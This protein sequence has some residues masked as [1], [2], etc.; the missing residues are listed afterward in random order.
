MSGGNHDHG[1]MSG[2]I[3][4]PAGGGHEIEKE[5]G[6]KSVI[7]KI[8]EEE[9]QVKKDDLKFP[10][11][12]IS[13]SRPKGYGEQSVWQ[14]V[15]RPWKPRDD[16]LTPSQLAAKKRAEKK[17]A[18]AEAERI[19]QQQSTGSASGASGDVEEAEEDDEP[20]DD[21]GQDD[22]FHFYWRLSLP[23]VYTRAGAVGRRWRA[24]EY[25]SP[26]PNTIQ[27]EPRVFNVGWILESRLDEYRKTAAA[28]DIVIWQPKDD[29]MK[30]IKT[31]LGMPTS[32]ISNTKAKT[33]RPC[34]PRRSEKHFS[35]TSWALKKERIFS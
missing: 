6:T 25:P 7:D 1:N 33:T 4:K 15:K 22:K 32:A 29:E 17:R 30:R 34:P 3:E 16:Q 9:E 5:E 26:E 23:Q 10:A 28:K 8:P 11:N 18:T 19:K 31:A 21:D 35:P 14:C 12:Y 27:Q 2:Q 13:I 20:G 24:V